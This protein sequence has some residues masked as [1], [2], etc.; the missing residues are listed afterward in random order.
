[1]RTEKNEKNKKRKSHEAE[2]EN[3]EEGQAKKRPKA[4][5]MCMRMSERELERG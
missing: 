2:K 5:T 1:M 3:K 4:E